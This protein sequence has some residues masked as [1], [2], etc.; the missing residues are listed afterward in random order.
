MENVGGGAC[1]APFLFC[2]EAVILP[3]ER[4]VIN[5]LPYFF[6]I[7]SSADDMI[8]VGTLKDWLAYIA[9]NKTLQC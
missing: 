6:I 5:V 2:V 7:R 3:S 4:I 8:M 9:M 1:D